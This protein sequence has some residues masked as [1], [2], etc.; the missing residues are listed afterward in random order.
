M[1]KP[2][3]PGLFKNAGLLAIQKVKISIETA[4]YRSP[5]VH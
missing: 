5:I 3:K 4:C 1:I 2:Q